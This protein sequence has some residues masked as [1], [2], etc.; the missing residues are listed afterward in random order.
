VSETY[1]NVEQ[2]SK[3]FHQ[4]GVFG[5]S[6]RV[7]H[8]VRDVS[9][10][11]RRGESVGVAGESGSGKSTVARML[12]GLETPT[13]GRITLAGDELPRKLSGA[14]HERLARLCEMVFQD[15]YVSLDP[16]QRV[17]H[18]LDEIQRIHFERTRAERD[19][20]TRELMEAVGMGSRYLDAVPRELSGGQRQRVAIA[21][22][23]APEPKILILDEAVSAL[24]VSIQ[25]QILNLLADLR[26]EL[27]LTYL[28]ISH[29]LAVV[30][31]V[32]DRVLILYRGRALEEGPAHE[33]F[34]AP[35]HPYTQL[36][37]RS[38]PQPG[39]ALSRGSVTA[40]APLD[41]GCL[42][43]HRC[44][45][46]HEACAEE[47][48]LFEIKAAHTSRCWL[49]ARNGEVAAP[50]PISAGLFTD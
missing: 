45:A 17:R 22:A 42:F 10:S 31:H 50:S 49:N 23:L 34:E 25:A 44:P 39:I 9:F 12:V 2:L 3:T 24:D 30:H 1:V 16:R 36:L 43:R 35:A 7:T 28:F 41:D 20:R 18:G 15:P 47:P 37:L 19:R 46:V 32:A 33:V 5:G 8:A 4:G 6:R 40:E 21:R 27:E 26:G 11:V 13:T 29:D 14:Q 48:P 38:V